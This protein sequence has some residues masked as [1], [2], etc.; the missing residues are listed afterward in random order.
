[1][2]LLILSA[3]VAD[4]IA[5]LAVNLDIGRSDRYQ[6]VHGPCLVGLRVLINDLPVDD[7]P[8]VGDKVRHHRPLDDVGVDPPGAQRGARIV[9]AWIHHALGCFGLHIDLSR[10]NT[11]KLGGE[12]VGMIHTQPC[13]VTLKAAIAVPT[14]LGRP[15]WL[16]VL[17]ENGILADKANVFSSRQQCC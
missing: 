16:A 15:C 6:D 17:I 1:M 8:L 2:A 9:K 3:G 12:E 5:E 4:E 7:G 11:A 10:H 13:K 14:Q